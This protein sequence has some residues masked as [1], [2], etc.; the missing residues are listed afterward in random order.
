MIIFDRR[1]QCAYPSSLPPQQ[2]TAHF[3]Y[4][5][6]CFILR[7][8]IKSGLHAG[9][10]LCFQT[11]IRNDFSLIGYQRQH[12]A[13]AFRLR[14]SKSIFERDPR[15]SWPPPTFRPC[16]D[17][18]RSSL[19]PWPRAWLSKDVEP[20]RGSSIFLAANLF[21]RNTVWTKGLYDA[22]TFR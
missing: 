3:H 18:S 8:L 9:K 14:C 6:D 22:F 5:Q 15:T 7:C 10:S 11:S 20:N 12:H 16:N 17:H 13:E 19:C 4:D 1:F 21:K 2:R